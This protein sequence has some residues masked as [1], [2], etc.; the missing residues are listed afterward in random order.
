MIDRIKSRILLLSHLFYYKNVNF[1]YLLV[2]FG[3]A[4]LV[5]ETASNNRKRKRESEV[6]IYCKISS[7]V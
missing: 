4:Q 3:L 6:K 1:R 2:D 5:D 7:V